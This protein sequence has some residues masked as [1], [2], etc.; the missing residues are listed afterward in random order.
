METAVVEFA[1][2][3]RSVEIKPAT[4]TNVE[5]IAALQ[6]LYRPYQLADKADALSEQTAT[7]ILAEA[8]AQSVIV[9]STSPDLHD[10]SPE[11]WA[12]WLIEH[13]DEFNAIQQVSGA[14]EQWE[15]MARGR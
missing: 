14:P 9:G 6:E 4:E 11:E 7:R 15:T 12:A 8:Y 5:F 1:W 13:P 3:G 10:M 2:S